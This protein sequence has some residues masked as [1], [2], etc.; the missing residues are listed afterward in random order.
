MGPNNQKGTSAGESRTH[1]IGRHERGLDAE[2]EVAP[3]LEGDIDVEVGGLSVGLR[4]NIHAKKLY[5][6]PPRQYCL[7][8]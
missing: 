5:I 2:S 3:A 6:S 7:E 8:S 4:P 1:R